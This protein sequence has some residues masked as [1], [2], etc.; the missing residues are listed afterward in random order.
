MTSDDFSLAD[1]STDEISRL[2][3][4]IDSIDDA[5]L[6][7]LSRRAEVARALAVEKRVQKL[8]DRDVPREE[9]VV[10]RVRGIAFHRGLPVEETEA[11]FRAIITM[12][13]RIQA[14]S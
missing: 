5:I 11:I 1:D 14:S 7:H 12:S 3:D 6:K 8:A 4:H 9:E 2:R 10:A 13:R